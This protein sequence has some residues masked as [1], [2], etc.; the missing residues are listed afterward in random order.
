M[1]E[2]R[3]A[4]IKAGLLRPN[5]LWPLDR[6]IAIKHLLRVK[7]VI[8]AELNLGQYRLEICVAYSNHSGMGAK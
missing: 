2:A 6:E 1:R 8:V 5:T 4:G 7:R 3:A